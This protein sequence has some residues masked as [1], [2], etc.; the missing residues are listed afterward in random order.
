MLIYGRNIVTIVRANPAVVADLLA[1]FWLQLA[2]LDHSLHVENE[3]TL[4][5]R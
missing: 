3:R 1:I 2:A 4:K 5:T